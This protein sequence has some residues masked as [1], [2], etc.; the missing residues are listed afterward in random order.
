MRSRSA[1]QMARLA[2]RQ[3]WPLVRQV[4][5]HL[6]ISLSQA[7]LLLVLLVLWRSGSARAEQASVEM[8][9]LSQVLLLALVDP[10]QWRPVAVLQ[11]MAGLS[12]CQEVP[13]PRVVGT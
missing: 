9:A 5:A 11:E 12:R 8:L 2:E 13:V 6:V 3:R 7:V 4:V 1:A 10:C